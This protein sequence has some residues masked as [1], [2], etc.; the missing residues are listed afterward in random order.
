MTIDTNLRVDG[1]G[2]RAMSAGKGVLT[3]AHE[4]GTIL[5]AS[6]SAPILH[7]PAHC[8]SSWRVSTCVG[9]KTARSTG[10]ILRT[11]FSIRLSRT[12]RAQSRA[13]YLP[14]HACWTKYEPKRAEQ[15]AYASKTMKKSTRMTSRCTSHT[16]PADSSPIRQP[17]LLT[18]T[19][20]TRS[21]EST[22]PKAGCTGCQGGMYMHTHGRQDQARLPEASSFLLAKHQR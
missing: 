2:A 5:V 9:E 18:K 22:E 19:T 7:R 11:Q 20:T 3:T 10:K 4:Q 13:E 17:A 15:D 21:V 12:R 1:T 14:T 8:P 6:P 16:S